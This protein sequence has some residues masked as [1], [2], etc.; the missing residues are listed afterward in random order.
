MALEA[1]GYKAIHNPSYLLS[2]EDGVLS[3][4]YEEIKQYDA[5]TD[6][7]IARFY[8]Q[9]DVMFPSS[10][11]ILTTRELNSWLE[12][13]KNHFNEHR[14]T[15]P[16]VQALDIEMYGADL[17][18]AEKFTQAYSRHHN[19]VIDY[20]SERSDDLLI[21]DVSEKN[22]WVKLCDFLN[23]PIPDAPYPVRNKALPIPIVLKNIF[24]KFKTGRK[25]IKAIN[26]VIG[27]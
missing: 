6:I 27:K 3:L 11:F 8:K 17:F 2:L 20:F 9:L 5:L 14:T 15:A 12:S 1:L 19:E 26:K 21:L 4:D 10:K 25:A 7:Q 23:K 18:E 22:K 24:R 16:H 13:C